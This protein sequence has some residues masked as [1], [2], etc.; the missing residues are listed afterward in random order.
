VILWLRVENNNKFTRGKTKVR[1][2]IE[3]YVLSDYKM[4]KTDKDGWE[5]KLTG[6]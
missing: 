6:A 1:A 3:N 2:D 5:Y 4:K